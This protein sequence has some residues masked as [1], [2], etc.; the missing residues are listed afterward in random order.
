MTA[1]LPPK[2]DRLPSQLPL[3]GAV[4]LELEEGVPVFRAASAV[5]NRVEVLLVK[6]QEGSLTVA[7]ESELDAYEELDDHLS[8]VNRA[9]RNSF[10]RVDGPQ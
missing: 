8:F 10:L 3:E 2:L 9:V 7:E 4:R 6:Q 1:Q 5:Q